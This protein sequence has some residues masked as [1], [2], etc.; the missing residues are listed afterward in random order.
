MANLE[1]SFY[2]TLK[3]YRLRCLINPLAT[4][5]YLSVLSKPDASLYTTGGT[6]ILQNFPD[7]NHYLKSITPSDIAV[8]EDSQ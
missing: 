3:Q 4:T 8:V 2:L 1:T 5:Y 6:L 7:F